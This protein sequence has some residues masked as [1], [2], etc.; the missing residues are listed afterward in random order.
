MGSRSI[1]EKGRRFWLLFGP[2]KSNASHR[3]GVRSKKINNGI[4]ANAADF[5]AADWLALC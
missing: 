4:S 5:I 1:N 3:C 2:L